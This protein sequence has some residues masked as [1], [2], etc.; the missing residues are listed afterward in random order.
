MNGK[1][2]ALRNQTMSKLLVSPLASS[3]SDE[4]KTLRSICDFPYWLRKY[5]D[6]MFPITSNGNKINNLRIFRK[7]P[8]I[9]TSMAL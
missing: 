5:N 8:N 6:W 2:I 3:K 4:K 7:Y 1:F 9:N